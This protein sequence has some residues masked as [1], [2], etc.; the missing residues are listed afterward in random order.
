MLLKYNVYV[1]LKKCITSKIII[2]E[3][4]YLFLD[5]KEAYF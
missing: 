5:A 3:C 4:D 1:V 2:N